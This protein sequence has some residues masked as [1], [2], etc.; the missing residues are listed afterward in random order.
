MP[1]G[2]IVP[3]SLPKILQQGERME[4]PNNAACSQKTYVNDFVH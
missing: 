1:F 4:R 2:G 3:Y